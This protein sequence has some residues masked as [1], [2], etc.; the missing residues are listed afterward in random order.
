MNSTRK[1]MHALGYAGL[2]PFVIPAIL[3]ATN[4]TY[5]PLLTSIVN[6]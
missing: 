6:A 2:I 5:S 1:T 4:S 3:I